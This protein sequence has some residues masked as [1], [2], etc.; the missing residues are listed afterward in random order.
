MAFKS[1]D[2]NGNWEYA[3]E[4]RVGD[5]RNNSETRVVARGGIMTISQFESEYGVHLAIDGT[6]LWEKSESRFSGLARLE[7][8]TLTW[9]AQGH[10]VERNGLYLFSYFTKSKTDDSGLITETFQMDD[11]TSQMFSGTFTE[12]VGSKGTQGIVNMR[13]MRHGQDL[14]WIPNKDYGISI[15][16]L[17]SRSNELAP[18][19]EC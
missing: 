18:S 11:P 16:G 1:V 17:G 12:I 9:R 14:E 13:K 2:L 5:F 8:S 15:V 3:S 19:Y 7:M 10:V 6:R 4:A